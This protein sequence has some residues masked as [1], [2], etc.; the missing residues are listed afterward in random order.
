MIPAA[1][2]YVNRK[3][4]QVRLVITHHARQRFRERWTVAF[5]GKPLRGAVDGHVAEWFGKAQRAEP[6]SRR[7]HTRLRRHGDD[8]L[9]FRAPPFTF[10]VQS[11]AI[12]TVELSD[13]G[14]RPLNR[15]ERAAVE[16]LLN[17]A[18]ANASADAALMPGP[19]PRPAAA[20]AAPAVFRVTGHVRLP[21]G[22]TRRVNLGSY[23]LAQARGEPALLARDRGFHGHVRRRLAERV[24][25]DWDL[26]AVFAGVGGKGVPVHVLDG[27]QLRTD[28]TTAD[29]AAGAVA[30]SA[31]TAAGS[32]PA[33]PPPAEA[34]AA[35][36][37]PEARV[38]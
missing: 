13:R 37:G 34:P 31:E 25:P 1:P 7:D 11:G 10:V 33:A 38:S 23:P 27:G 29:T 4:Q 15:P 36:T 21:D 20:P 3:G 35:T 6:L 9:F 24:P 17:A 2:S 5:P 26:V 16:T 22:Q 14:L 28:N 19:L 8:T 18:D 32:A 30:E 12:L